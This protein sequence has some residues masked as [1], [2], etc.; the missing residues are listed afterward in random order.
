MPRPED[1][2]AEQRLMDRIMQALRQ[3]PF[4]QTGQKPTKSHYFN[5]TLEELAEMLEANRDFLQKNVVPKYQAE[6]E[7]LWQYRELV[8][9]LRFLKDNVTAHKPKKAQKSGQKTDQQSLLDGL[10]WLFAKVEEQKE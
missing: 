9:G 1:L 2:T 7:E 5:M 6:Q 10:A 8:R 4:F 3:T